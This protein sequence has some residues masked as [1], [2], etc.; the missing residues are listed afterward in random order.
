[1]NRVDADCAAVQA[2][3]EAARAAALAA[4]S[5]PPPLPGVGPTGPL[6]PCFLRTYFGK[7]EGQVTMDNLVTALLFTTRP[8]QVVNRTGL[9]GSYQV[10]MEFDPQPLQ[11]GPQL[12][13][14]APDAKPSLFT[15]LQDQLGLKLVPSRTVR[16]TLVIDRLERP[17]EN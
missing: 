14:P 11:S 16:P 2:E 17:T 7:M 6:P 5:P 9:S 13:P 10:T 8:R 1:L 15:A 3:R 4:G 12:A